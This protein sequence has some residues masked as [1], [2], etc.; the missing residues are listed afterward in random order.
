MNNSKLFPLKKEKNYYISGDKCYSENSQIIKRNIVL[1]IYIIIFY[2]IFSHPLFIKVFS[3]IFSSI[4]N[5]TILLDNELQFN[6]LGQF[7]TSCIFAIVI[8]LLL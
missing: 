2:I 7:I 8:L 6:I 1:A 5:N 4:L 3:L